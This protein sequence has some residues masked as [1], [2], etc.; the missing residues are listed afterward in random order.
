MEL[1]DF[2][3]KFRTS[4]VHVVDGKEQTNAPGLVFFDSHV[5]ND[6]DGFYTTAMMDGFQGIVAL[7]FHSVDSQWSSIWYPVETSLNNFR[8]V[9]NSRS[10]SACLESRGVRDL[11][12]TWELF[13]I[14]CGSFFYFKVLYG[15]PLCICGVN[16]SRYRSPR[17]RGSC[18]QYLDGGIKWKLKNLKDPKFELVSEDAPDVMESRIESFLKSK[19]KEV[20]DRVVR[21]LQNHLKI[22]DLYSLVMGYYTIQFDVSVLDEMKPSS[23]PSSKRPYENIP[24]NM[25]HEPELKRTRLLR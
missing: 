20:S 9:C 21:V 14:W 1:K 23:K 22:D 6:R 11:K 7:K 8:D 4:A 12:C 25:D 3:N 16:F 19:A 18:K 13:H 17:K 5:A 24:S 10:P 15:I 2:I